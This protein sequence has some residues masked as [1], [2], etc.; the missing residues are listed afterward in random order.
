MWKW[1]RAVVLAAVALAACASQP[2]E[3]F[4]RSG[5]PGF[6]HGVWQGLIAWFALVGHIF[7]SGI[8]I[9]AFP[10]TGWWYEF[11][12]LLGAGLWA[13]FFWGNVVAIASDRY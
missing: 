3:D 1:R 10:N 13:G 8:T 12:F 2:I 6:F 5:T 7:N 4:D 9:Y 11:G